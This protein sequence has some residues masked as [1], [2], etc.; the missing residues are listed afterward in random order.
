MDVKIKVEDLENEMS[1]KWMQKGTRR[2]FWKPRSF[3]KRKSWNCYTIQY[4]KRV[5]FK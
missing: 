5:G 4:K 2:V 3:E 1:K